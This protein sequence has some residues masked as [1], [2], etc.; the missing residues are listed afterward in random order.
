M[1]LQELKNLEHFPKGEALRNGRDKTLTAGQGKIEQNRK[2][3]KSQHDCRSGPHKHINLFRVTI[4]LQVCFTAEPFR[5]RIV[6]FR[7][8]LKVSV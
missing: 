2:R 4:G 5:G 7:L 8:E 6:S 3:M 1:E